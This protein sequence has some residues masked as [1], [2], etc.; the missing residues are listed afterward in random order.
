MIG[1]RN[2]SPTTLQLSIG[3]GWTLV[4]PGLP[5][6]RLFITGQWMIYRRDVPI[7]PQ[8]TMNF[9]HDLGVPAAQILLG[10]LEWQQATNRSRVFSVACER[11]P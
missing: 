11:A 1:W 4:R 5:P 3:L 10:S 2:H 9:G 7:A 8:T 6:M